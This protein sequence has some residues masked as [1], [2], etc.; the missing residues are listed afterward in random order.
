MVLGGIVQITLIMS[1][2][3]VVQV[4]MDGTKKAGEI[5]TSTMMFSQIVVNFVGVTKV[6]TQVKF[7]FFFVFFKWFSFLLP[8]FRI[9]T[10][11]FLAKPQLKFLH[12]KSKVDD[13]E[14][15]LHFYFFLICSNRAECESSSFLFSSF[16]AYNVANFIAYKYD[17]FDFHKFT[18]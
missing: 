11:N 12:K 8:F 4:E 10:S 17:R 18:H 1:G 15:E 7:L 14:F 16:C 13:H 6:R 2:V 3:Q 9:L 5:L